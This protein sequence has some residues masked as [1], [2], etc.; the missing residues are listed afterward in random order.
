MTTMASRT[1]LTIFMLPLLFLGTAGELFAF[2]TDPAWASKAPMQEARSGLG[3]AVLNGKIYA[4]GGASATGFSSTNEEYDPA[5]DTWIF[6]ASMPTSRSDFGIAVYENKIYCIGGYIKGNPPTGVNAAAVN[7]AYDP[8][9]NTWT[10]RAQMPTARLNLRAN[11]VNGKIYLIGGIPMP[12]TCRTLNEVYDPASDT[13][14]TKAP[15]PT[16]VDSYASAV[17]GSKIF[18]IKS[19]LTQIY[20]AESDS[21]STGAAPP[22]NSFMPSSATI[23]TSNS[24]VR[25]FL[26]GANTE[27][28]YWMLT[29]QGFTTQRYD[30]ATDNWTAGTPMPTGR[31]DAGIA[32]ANDKLFAIGGYNYGTPSGP[33]LTLNRPAIYSSANEQYTPSLDVFTPANNTQA[34]ETANTPLPTPMAIP[35]QS[36]TITPLQTL[37]PLPTRSPT[38]TSSPT[39]TPSLSSSLTHSPTF[40]PSPTQTPNQSYS[41][42]T[43]SNPNSGSTAKD[44]STP[45]FPK[46]LLL[47]AAAVIAAISV[48][49]AA[50]KKHK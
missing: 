22:T 28:A 46:F 4:I 7:E 29:N 20:D 23:A 26:F 8:T 18:L 21:W 9:T 50:K 5:T 42:S 37:N 27:G 35:T 33:G 48:I 32:V 6:K 10:T 16:G 25:I 47:S 15:I 17:V 14:A 19:G 44:V 13:W 24:P 31:F 2:A 39:Q 1:A 38:S 49:L 40:K 41:S 43:P 3:V 30:P 11:V 12:D 36:Q 34:I 45:Q